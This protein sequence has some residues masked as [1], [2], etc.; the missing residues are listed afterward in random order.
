MKITLD[1]EYLERALAELTVLRGFAGEV[2]L[3]HGFTSEDAVQRGVDAETLTKIMHTHGLMTIVNPYISRLGH[4][5][6]NCLEEA[7]TRAI[8]PRQ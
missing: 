8:A 1:F 5:G 3:A 2:M 4:I 7:E 6:R